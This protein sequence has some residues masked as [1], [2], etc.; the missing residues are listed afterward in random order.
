[1]KFD[2]LQILFFSLRKAGQERFRSVTHAYYRHANA[3]LLIY[4]VTLYSSFENILVWLNEIKELTPND[5]TI[6]LI[7]NKVDKC[8]RVVSRQAGERLAI[9]FQ[10]N[11]LETSAKTGQNVEL[12]FMTTAQ[13]LL[14]KR[15][16]ST[17]ADGSL[18]D[19]IKIQNTET[20]NSCC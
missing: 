1:M 5:M 2:R 20:N 18:N 13:I 10:I 9:D 3:L 8:R 11:F 4:D 14:D 7:G 15:L 16:D 19:K 12:A 17:N 6:I